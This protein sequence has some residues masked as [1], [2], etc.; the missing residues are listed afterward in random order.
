MRLV[1]EINRFA[2]L[3]SRTRKNTHTHIVYTFNPF[4]AHSSAFSIVISA[5]KEAISWEINFYYGAM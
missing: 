2:F 4:P 5:L 1:F 3:Y